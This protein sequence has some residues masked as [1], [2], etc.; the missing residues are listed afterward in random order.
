MLV[1]RIYYCVFG[2]DGFKVKNT[3]FIERFTVIGKTTISIYSKKH[4]YDI[5]ITNF[6]NRM[7]IGL[8]NNTFCWND[9]LEQKKNFSVAALELNFLIVT[10]DTNIRI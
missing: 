3:S 1:V 5:F 2:Y 9:D 8:L 4:K 7:C 6:V 10:S